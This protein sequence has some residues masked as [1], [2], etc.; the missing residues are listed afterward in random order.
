[1]GVVSATPVSRRRVKDWPCSL[2]EEIVSRLSERGK[3]HLEAINKK[4]AAF[5]SVEL[6]LL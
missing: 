5:F 6:S 1:V 3:Y 2:R 4:K